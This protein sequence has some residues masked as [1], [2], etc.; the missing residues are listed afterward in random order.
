MRAYDDGRFRLEREGLIVYKGLNGTV[1]MAHARLY[2][3]PDQVPV[4]IVGEPKDNPGMS[5]SNTIETVAA[6]VQDGWLKDRPDFALLAYDA[7]AQ[8][9]SEVT[10]ED[11][12]DED[13]P[14]L[15][16]F[17]DPHWQFVSIL[18][19]LGVMPELF[20]P[21]D[22]MIAARGGTE[23]ERLRDQV[24]KTNDAQLDAVLGESR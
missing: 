17:R 23:A 5:V 9:F 6:A 4:V 2:E 1:G 16:R 19:V 8:T 15:A 11:V 10:F 20:N 18:D 3:A 12:T 21:E 24:L 14:T 7:D 22:Y 13:D